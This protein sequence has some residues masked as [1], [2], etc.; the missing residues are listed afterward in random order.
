MLNTDKEQA[1]KPV[2][3]GPNINPLL[4]IV[5]KG[6]NCNILGVTNLSET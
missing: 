5:S 1:C 4:N 2:L 3:V 6:G